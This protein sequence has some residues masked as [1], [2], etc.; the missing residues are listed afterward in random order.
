MH[1]FLLSSLSLYI[2]NITFV[3]EAVCYNHTLQEDK[4]MIGCADARLLCYDYK[5]KKMAKTN[6]AFVSNIHR[7]GKVGL[8]TQNYFYF[9]L[10]TPQISGS[11][12]IMILCNF[13][14]ILH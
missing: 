7:Y 8:M 12:A 10:W 2:S 6:A 9:N 5:T 14:F 13:L 3:A 1:L 11:H 4:V